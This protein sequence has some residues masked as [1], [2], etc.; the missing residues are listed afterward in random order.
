MVRER[1]LVPILAGTGMAGT[2][3]NTLV[4][5]HAGCAP[6]HGSFQ[7]AASSS[8]GSLPAAP[9]ACT[10]YTPGA[11]AACVCLPCTAGTWGTGGTMQAAKCEP[12]SRQTLS[13]SMVVRGSC[14]SQYA[15]SAVRLQLQADAQRYPGVA[16]TAAS[17]RLVTSKPEPLDSEVSSRAPQGCTSQE[18][19]ATSH[20]VLVWLYYMFMRCSNRGCNFP[21][22]CQQP[23][24]MQWYDVLA[25]KSGHQCICMQDQLRVGCCMLPS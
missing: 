17:V 11:T 15:A 14:P 13:M 21:A 5:L 4:D 9:P 6:G 2:D 8:Y 3:N 24:G 19:L 7:A 22:A 16:P 12:T 10:Q 25:H 1:V 18:G 20:T 23:C